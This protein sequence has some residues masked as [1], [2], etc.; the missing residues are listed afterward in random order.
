MEQELRLHLLQ[1]KELQRMELRQISLGP[2]IKVRG[3]GT[4]VLELTDKIS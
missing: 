4:S 3:N 1:V 2:L